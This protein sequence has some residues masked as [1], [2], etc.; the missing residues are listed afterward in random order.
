MY[1][2]DT[3]FLTFVFP[4]TYLLLECN[5]LLLEC[6]AVLTDYDLHSKQFYKNSLD[7]S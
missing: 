2:L 3:I 1:A 4:I 7:F 6:N 5:Y